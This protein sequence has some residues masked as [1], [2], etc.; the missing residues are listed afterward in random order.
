M[1][2]DPKHFKDLSSFCD[3][4]ESQGELVRIREEV[5]PHLE[6]TEISTRLLAEQGPAVLYERV[7]GYAMPVLNNLFGT[8]RRVGLAIG[9]DLHQ[10]EELGE[11]LA[12]LRQP[13]PPTGGVGGLLGTARKL[14]S[15]RHMPT[16]SKKSAPWQ[17]V[18]YQGA[19]VDLTRLPIQGCWP[20][21][22]APL[23][24]WPVVITRGADQGAVNLGI[25]RMQLLG[26]NRLIMR[27]LKHRGG[28]QHSRS[29]RK[30]MPVAV[31][32]GCDPGT[33]LAA[34]TP[35]P[36]T[37]SEYAFAG[38]L[39]E[40]SVTVV[41]GQESGLPIPYSAE[42]VL[43][44]TVDLNDLADEGPYGDHTG[45][46]NEVERFPVF[47]VQRISM[48]RNAIYL[49]THTGR[50]P[51]EP[52]VLAL[53]LNR[54]FV[55]LLKKQF[56]EISAFH[57]PAEACSYRVAVIAINKQYAGHAFRMMAGVWG[58]LRQFLYTKYL[59]VVDSSVDCH[60]WDAVMAAVGRHVDARRDLQQLTNTP[61]DYLDFAS[62]VAGLG[63]KLGLDATRKSGAELQVVPHP[64]VWPEAEALQQWA[65]AAQ[66][67]HAGE[68]VQ[69]H[70]RAAC[71]MAVVSMHK[72]AAGQSGTLAKQLLAAWHPGAPRQI[73]LMDEDVDVTLWDD[74]WWVVSTRSDAG[75]DLYRDEIHGGFVMDATHK[76][77]G[78]TQREWGRVL[79][80][81]QP[82]IDRVSEKWPRLGLPGTGKPIW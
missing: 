3:F 56:P 6:M 1:G 58:F 26:K 13:D 7:S 18:V 15:V 37:L 11:L 69:I 8:E 33:I 52:S 20:G 73:W 49:S 71:A 39:M 12:Y 76:W 57:L 17:Q 29:Y 68:I 22:V 36:D 16:R 51:D 77:P 10:L 2:H 62:P 41:T 43:E 40:Q 25:Y 38:L 54:V 32:I 65:E 80:M 66:Q 21:D 53:A 74:L 4:L 19:A 27:W 70:L 46:Y 48:R 79:R 81:D 42:I 23:I 64:A 63:G 31:A 30:P 24:T 50:P 44:G 67:R 14:S 55:P 72:T 59:I 45:Y 28:A 9:A 82:T 61:I 75:R 60:N 5:D 34:V 35:V 47:T 78:E